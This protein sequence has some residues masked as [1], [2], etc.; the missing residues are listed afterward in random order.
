VEGVDA[1]RHSRSFERI[2]ICACAVGLQAC[3]GPRAATTVDEAAP[4]SFLTGPELAHRVLGSVVLIDNAAGRQERGTGLI[5][6]HDAQG[7]LA[8]TAAHVVRRGEASDEIAGAAEEAVAAQVSVRLCGAKGPLE[9]LI[10]TP[11]PL[12]GQHI[13][14]IALV[15]IVVAPQTPPSEVRLMADPGSVRTFDEA[16]VA[17]IGG[18]C[19]VGGSSGSFQRVN[20]GGSTLAVRMPGA[21]R[22]SSGAPVLTGRGV[23]GLLNAYSGSTDFT[24]VTSIEAIREAALA[25]L[26]MTWWLTPS[27]N[28]PPSEPDAASRELIDALDHY[29]VA[30]RNAHETL[31]RDHVN[32]GELA[33][34][35][36]NYN[37]AFDKFFGARNKHDGTVQRYWGPE[38]LSRYRVT[39]DEV[40]TLHWN[41]LD[42]SREGWV[43]Q[44]YRT[45]VVPAEVRRRMTSLTA[46]IEKLHKD[47]DATVS[48]LSVHKDAKDL[49]SAQP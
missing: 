8:V 15:R 47:V 19:A 26:P 38:A 22:G 49:F 23:A 5:V 20:T 33:G 10:G 37:V 16:W 9:R 48:V 3:A 34:I 17:G 24:D 39:R 46:A 18:D 4:R 30:M 2:A 21:Y 36:R 13:R 41:F 44:I 42:L 45:N 29:M 14:D 31:V 25:T 11:I 40:L 7:L 32:E 35:V 6:G 12:S 28:L 27:G 43:N 1:M